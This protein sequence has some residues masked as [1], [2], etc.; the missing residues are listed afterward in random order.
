MCVFPG[1]ITVAETGLLH[2]VFAECTEWDQTW[3]LCCCLF[4]KR[5]RSDWLSFFQ[6]KRWVMN[7][8][9]LTNTN[10]VYR[11]H[12]SNSNSDSNCVITN[13]VAKYFG[14]VI[15]WF[16]GIWSATQLDR[17]WKGGWRVC[18]VMVKNNLVTEW[19]K[20]DRWN[21]TG[22]SLLL[23]GEPREVMRMEWTKTEIHEEKMPISLSSTRTLINN[24]SKPLLSSCC[25]SLS[26]LCNYL[27][28]TVILIN[29]SIIV[30]CS[31][32]L[33]CND[34]KAEEN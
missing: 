15:N 26:I 12:N 23:T 14:S 19:G 8:V 34:N 3:L 30:L 24:S 20:R 9:L 21:R 17:W 31:M 28:Y 16:G 11:N 29:V 18:T 25:V 22:N 2:K 32:I 10:H 33:C 4:T 5:Y 6:L 27:N 7:L 1:P 13:V